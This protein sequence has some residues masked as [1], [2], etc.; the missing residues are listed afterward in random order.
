[1]ARGRRAIWCASRSSISCASWW[2]IAW[3]STCSPAPGRWGSR[4]VSRGAT[5]AIFVERDRENV[6]LIHRNIGTLRYQDRATVRHADAYRW[7]RS[8]TPDDGG[9]VVV[10]LD[11]PYR[12]Y[13]IHARHLNRMLAGLV[14]KLPTGSVVVLESGRTLDAR[15]LPD[16]DAW[17]I[18]RYGGTHLAL[19]VIDPPDDAATFGGVE[20]SPD[21]E[22]ATDAEPEDAGDE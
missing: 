11:P 10:F 13:E 8:F 21:R 5:Q 15:I 3:S 12:E 22:T 7:A 19:R 9:P 4:R 17:D 16:F 18:R 6:A 2:S 14:E 1:M 20:D